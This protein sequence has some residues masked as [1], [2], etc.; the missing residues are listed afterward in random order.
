M[1]KEIWEWSANGPSNMLFPPG[2]GG[3]PEGMNRQEVNDASR[4]NLASIRRYYNDPEWIH[5]RIQGPSASNVGVFSRTG[6]NTCTITLA[7]VDLS[8]YFRAG[9]VVKITNGGGVGVDL[10]TQCSINSTYGAGVTTI[11]T[12]AT[13]DA[14]ASDIYAHSASVLRAQGLLDDSSQFFIPAT[15]DSAGINAAIAAADA[16]GGGIVF[17]NQ[18]SYSIATQIDITGTLGN[19]VIWGKH[20]QVTLLR[21]AAIG[22]IIN[23]SN[24]SKS[25]EIRNVKFDGDWLTNPSGNGYGL[26]IAN[27]LSVLID[28]CEFVRCESGIRITGTSCKR[29]S[30]QNS[31]FTFH[32]YGISTGAANDTHEG[33]I[34]GCT[35]DG[36]LMSLP[37]PASLRLSGTWKVYG[38]QLRNWTH[39]TLVPTGIHIWDR[40]VL[41]A[42][43]I[44]STVFGN[45]VHGP[46]AATG[47]GIW[48]GASFSSCIG[49][50]ITGGNSTTGIK[51]GSNTAAAPAEGVTCSENS[52]V[53]GNLS[54]QV[55]EFARYGTIAANVLYPIAGTAISLASDLT[56]VRGN[57][58]VNAPVGLDLLAAASENLIAGNSFSSITTAGIIV[59][60]GASGNIVE[61]NVIHG[62]PTKAIDIEAGSI[63]TLVRE[64]YAPSVSTPVVNAS[65]T[66]RICRNEQ[67]R[68][69]RSGSASGVNIDLGASPGQT[70]IGAQPLP[71][72][73]GVGTYM[74]EYEYSMTTTSNFD[75][76][77]SFGATGVPATDTI[78][79]TN[80]VTGG[81][82]ESSGFV[83]AVFVDVTDATWV[84]WS[85]SARRN[86][87]T[88][89]DAT[90]AVK[91]T[92]VA[93]PLG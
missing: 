93:D 69:V 72:G 13:I 64:N 66:S 82:P 90:S 10:V 67:V 78:V 65:T 52:I 21:T 32:R 16:A 83:G 74:I 63:G 11:T 6:A 17:L 20:P 35:F 42:G 91:I 3:W 26:S 89:G 2:D 57:N 44:R 14:A 31:N 33:M 24:A 53:A 37:A 60:S 85:L 9:R 36:S 76:Y 7:G 18:L 77:I 25:L 58:I 29:I 28:G 47:I 34:H 81:S 8:S 87:A 15:A 27:C 59:R 80:T 4:E 23:F 22:S 38:N 86:S 49:N 92:K 55:S 62:T 61:G 48:M 12:K 79:D 68:D 75:H 43:G 70:I 84:Y 46:S 50:I 88:N 40:T 30:I 45:V 73:G 19:V 56:V 71:G 41:D 1:S 39:A 5:A 54:I 51:I